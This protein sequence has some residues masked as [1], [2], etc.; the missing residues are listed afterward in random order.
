MK[1]KSITCAYLAEQ[2]NYLIGR[3][4]N[5]P[6]FLDHKKANAMMQEIENAKV[7]IAESLGA[8]SVIGRDGATQAELKKF[9]EMGARMNHSI[10]Y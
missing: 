2:A 6:R 7:L 4:E 8:I 3:I 9:E 1:K 5:A 10:R